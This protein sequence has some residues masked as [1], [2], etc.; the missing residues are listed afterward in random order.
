MWQKSLIILNTERNPW[1][2][3]NHVNKL[4]FNDV[5]K[6]PQ[7]SKDDFALRCIFPRA[8]L[9]LHGDCTCEVSIIV[10]IIASWTCHHHG[11]HPLSL[12][13]TFLL[14]LIRTCSFWKCKCWVTCQN[15]WSHIALTFDDNIFAMFWEPDL[16]VRV[17]R[18]LACARRGGEDGSRS[19]R[20]R[21]GDSPS[22][23]TSWARPPRGCFLILADGIKM[24][25][26]W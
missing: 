26:A 12:F 17:A 2:A 8:Y 21:P 6:M 20:P 24:A 22:P 5:S 1:S 16:C 25:W 9:V 13:F 23:L 19:A 4:L 7:L 11:R 14:L 3:Q 15:D 18:L 10:H